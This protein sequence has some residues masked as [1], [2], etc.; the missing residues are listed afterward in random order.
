MRGRAD[1]ETLG[2]AGAVPAS[3]VAPPADSAFGEGRPVKPKL[4]VMFATHNGERWIKRVLDA[5]AA[6]DYSEPWRL[7]VI[8][9]ASTDGTAEIVRQYAKTLPLTFLSEPRV[10]KNC[11]L[12]RGL[13]VAADADLLI[14][15]DDDAPPRPMFLRAWAKLFDT[16]LDYDFFGGRVEAEFETPPPAWIQRL[17]QS[18]SAVFAQRNLPTGPVAFDEIFGPNMCVRSRIF[19]SGL[20]F[21]EEIGPNGSDSNYPMGSET[22]F[23]GRAAAAGFKPM[24]FADPVVGHIVRPNQMTFAYFEKVAYRAGRRDAITAYKGGRL[25]SN[26]WSDHKIRRYAPAWV[27][28]ALLRIRTWAALDPLKR[29]SRSWRYHWWRGY[30]DE[31][32]SYVRKAAAMRA[33]SEP[34]PRI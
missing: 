9:N 7:I 19:E 27:Q 13:K 31:A 5:Y 24:F 29:S 10:G 32:R 3:M 28:R 14:L 2:L 17:V 33:R 4:A 23:C 34:A 6:Q 15:T 20:S 16:H 26:L 25:S 30:T 11:A 18:S 12:N 1:A 21:N 22:E 8:D